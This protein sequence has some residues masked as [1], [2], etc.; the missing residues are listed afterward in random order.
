MDCTGICRHHP[1]PDCAEEARAS[2]MPPH[3]PTLD[4][5]FTDALREFAPSE[6]AIQEK[7]EA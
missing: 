7:E 4:P 3:L 5:L 6:E 1:C 2:R